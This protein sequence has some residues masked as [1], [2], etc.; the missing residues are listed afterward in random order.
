M[1]DQNDLSSDSRLETWEQRA[2]TLEQRLASAERDLAQ[3]REELTRVERRRRIERELAQSEA[4][5]LETASILVEGA[6]G[7][8][9]EGGR[10]GDVRGAVAELKKRKPFLFRGVNRPTAM[11]GRGSAVNPLESSAAQ[12]RASGDRGALMQYLRAKRGS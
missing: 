5:D 9:S 6:L 10:D 1:S 2:M 12:A 7:Q 3:S 4:I 11:S 8:I